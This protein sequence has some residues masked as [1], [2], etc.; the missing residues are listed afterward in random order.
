METPPSQESR[1]HV[2]Q[3]I[4]L[5][6]TSTRSSSTQPFP[7][8]RSISTVNQLGLGVKPEA[9][10]T[11]LSFLILR[12]WKISK[13]QRC[14]NLVRSYVSLEDDHEESPPLNKEQME[15]HISVLKSLVKAHNKNNAI[16]PIRLNFD[17]EYTEVRG[18]RIV[19]GKAVVDNDLKKLFKEV[20]QTPLTQKIIEFTRPEYKMP[21]NQTLD[22]SARGWFERLPANSINEWAE[23]REAFAARYSV[24]R[25]C[26]KEPH[27]I[28]KIVRKAN[29][30]L[31][32]FKERWTVETGFIMGVLE[33]MKISSFMDSLKFPEL[34]KRFSNKA[35][36]T[37]DEMMRRV[38]DFVRS[39]E[40]FARTKLPKG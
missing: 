36:V 32:A 29:E 39:E 23:L 1:D 19:K 30:L 7:K 3:V 21:A 38:D 10:L 25:A 2:S 37:V 31:T 35:H 15:G 6:D 22:G 5:P 33:V 8:Y 26:F 11:R 28:T 9:R 14:W 20:V 16:D 4:M 17:G 27:E 13:G 18:N 40:A 12:Y 34:A 24:R